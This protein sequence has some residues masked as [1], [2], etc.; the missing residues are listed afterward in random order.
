[1]FLNKKHKR[2]L[3]IF[4][5]VVAIIIILSMVLFLVPSLLLP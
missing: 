3:Q 1:M 2:W 5:A 4:W